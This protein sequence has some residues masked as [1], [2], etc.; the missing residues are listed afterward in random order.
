MIRNLMAITFLLLLLGSC[1]C[2]K[3]EVLLGPTEMWSKAV[4]FDPN[5]ELVFVADTPEGRER[6]VLCSHYRKDGCVAGSGKRIKVRLVE[7]IVIQ[8]EN[9]KKACLAA[10]EIGQWYAYNWVFDDVTNEPVLEDYV[11]KAFD[12]KKPTDPKD[13]TLE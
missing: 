2:S 10:L 7:L 13:C 5:I 3:E 11:L 6:R 8:Y 4:K 1:S 9:T 12:A